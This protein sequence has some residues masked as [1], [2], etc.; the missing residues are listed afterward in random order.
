MNERPS[1]QA[2]LREREHLL[3][4]LGNSPPVLRGTLR[5]HMNRCGNPG[6]RCHDEDKPIL[7]GPYQYLSH[8]YQNRTRTILLTENKL[9]HARKW[10][11]NY[12]RMM[13]TVYRL[14]EVNFRILRYYHANLDKKS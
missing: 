13:K 7:H 8:R 1:Y 2:L 4:Q 5:Q 10:V 11:A 14:A 6:C 9:P 12:R 3:E